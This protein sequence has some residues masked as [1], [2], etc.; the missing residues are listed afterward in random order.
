MAESASWLALALFI[1][2]GGNSGVIPHKSCERA[3]LAKDVLRTSKLFP[4]RICS[5]LSFDVPAL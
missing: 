4:I 3:H 5:E 1:L 2:R